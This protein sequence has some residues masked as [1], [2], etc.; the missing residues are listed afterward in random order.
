MNSRT[1]DK[2]RL[3]AA[4]GAGSFVV[5]VADHDGSLRAARR[6]VNCLEQL[7]PIRGEF[8][9]AAHLVSARIYFVGHQGFAFPVRGDFL[10]IRIFRLLQFASVGFQSAL[11]I[12]VVD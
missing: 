6:E 10:V 5:Y 4:G 2:S 9:S 8:I 1:A 7:A 3:A 12:R 11:A